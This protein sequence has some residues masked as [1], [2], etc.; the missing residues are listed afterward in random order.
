[1]IAI[2]LPKLCECHQTEMSFSLDWNQSGGVSPAWQAPDDAI[3]NSHK[4]VQ[5]ATFDQNK[6]HASAHLRSSQRISRYQALLERHHQ[7]LSQQCHVPA[8]GNAQLTTIAFLRLFTTQGLY[9]VACFVLL[10]MSMELLAAINEL[11]Y[12]QL[13]RSG[14]RRAGRQQA[15]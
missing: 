4:D 10:S 9:I 6:T 15:C 7:V 11:P 5:Q 13:H 8:T 3:D 14:V 12:T 1:M 2:S